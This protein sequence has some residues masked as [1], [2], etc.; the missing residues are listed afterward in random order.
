MIAEL[1]GLSRG[2][3][4]FDKKSSFD[5]YRFASASP[6]PFRL[7]KAQQSMKVSDAS[8]FPQWGQA[9][10]VAVIGR[11]NVGKSTLIK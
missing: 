3:R 11:S 8:Q 10:E 5:K 2:A 7:G 9:P 6:Y 4:N 1:P